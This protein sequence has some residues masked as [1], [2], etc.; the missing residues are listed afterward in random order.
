MHVHFLPYE[1]EFGGWY[2]CN[3]DVVEGKAYFFSIHGEVRKTGYETGIDKGS[4]SLMC[5]WL[6][7][8]LVFLR[9]WVTL[10]LVCW[11]VE[12]GLW[13]FSSRSRLL[14]PPLHEALCSR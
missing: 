2:D 14:C 5:L 4:F 3:R 8:V 13:A 6:C 10:I 9:V 1:V 7:Y 12:E 11:W